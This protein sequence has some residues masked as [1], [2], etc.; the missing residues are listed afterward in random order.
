M[1]RKISAKNE[2]ILKEKFHIRWGDNLPYTPWLKNATR[3]DIVEFCSEMNFNEGAEIGVRAGAFSKIFLDKNPKLHMRCI[4]SWEPYSRVGTKERQEIFYNECIKLLEP[5]KDRVEIIKMPSQQALSIIPD[6]SLDFVYIDA[7]HD[8]D[9]VV[10]DLIGWN[11]KVKRGGLI[12]G[13]DYYNFYNGGVVTA[14]DAY[15]KAHNIKTW[16]VTKESEPSFFWIK[17]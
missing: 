8:F 11:K 1:N 7:M 12:S 16:C 17:P 4:D 5:Y 2:Q 3:N 10:M 13:H 6:N 15:V 9:N 14:V